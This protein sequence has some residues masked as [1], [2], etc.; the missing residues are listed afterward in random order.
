[1]EYP[2]QI[3]NCVHPA[4]LVVKHPAVT[5][6]RWKN[7]TCRGH[8]ADILRKSLWLAASE[9]QDIE[10]NDRSRRLLCKL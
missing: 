4:W 9:H 8:M 10:V 7:M 5:L 3:R 2:V 1:M 6:V